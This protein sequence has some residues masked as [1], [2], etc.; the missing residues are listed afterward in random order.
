MRIQPVILSGGSGTRLWPLSR[1]GYPKQL[2]ELHGEGTL[3]QQ[4]ATRL[5]EG[6]GFAA[7]LVVCNDDQRFLIAEQLRENAVTPSMI[8][9][10]PVARS[11]GPA[12]AVAALTAD[13]PDQTVL[14]AMPADHFIADKVAFQSAIRSAADC[15]MSGYLMTLGVKPTAPHIGYGYI[16]AGVAL[17]DGNGACHVTRF[18]EKPDEATARAYLA[19]GKY[20][21]NAG[22][23]VFRADTYLAALEK[24]QPEMLA[25]CR[26]ALAQGRRD[27]DFLRLDGAAFARAPNLSVDYA[28]MEYADNAG[29]L[30]V[31]FAWSD[32]GGFGA[33][34]G[35]GTKDAAGNV[36][37]GDV[38]LHDVKNSYVRADKR[39]V[40][41]LG[42]SNVVVVETADAL[43][44]ADMTRVDDV[45]ELVARLRR[46]NRH[47]E[48]SHERVWRPWGFY[49]Q[50]DRG[51]RF[52]VKQIMVKPGGQLSLQMHHHRAEHWVVVSGTAKVTVG[53]EVNLLGPNE[54]AYIPIGAT[55]RLENPGLVPLYLIEVQSGDYL[56]EDD[57]VRLE[58]VYRRAG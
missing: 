18:K 41:V 11:T 46:K 23:F 50:L 44:V 38:M 3:L 52:Q 22:I 37:G 40:T 35:L 39:L 1:A 51:D 32:V 31:D 17:P 9:L 20:L 42:L 36:T 57:I 58:D 54:T 45:K 5:P 53:E 12:L 55:H 26:K 16:E 30:P 8:L 2:Q 14:V 6:D 15:A 47:E 34:W 43:L 33:L 21:W 10:E 49:E 29:V 56:G 13:K 19:T 25:A 24:L 27:L 7:P 28:V 48:H 4:A